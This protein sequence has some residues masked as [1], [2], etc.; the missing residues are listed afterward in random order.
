[1]ELGTDTVPEEYIEELVTPVEGRGDPA[2]TMLWSPRK[3]AGHKRPLEREEL[4]ES[5]EEGDSESG[6]AAAEI[7]TDRTKEGPGVTNETDHVRSELMQIDEGEDAEREPAPQAQTD[8]TTPVE[9]PMAIETDEGKAVQVNDEGLVS[10][11]RETE[12][13]RDLREDSARGT[14]SIPSGGPTRAGYEA[15]WATKERE[16]RS[17]CAREGEVVDDVWEV[18][19]LRLAVK[20][21]QV[22]QPGQVASG[23]REGHRTNLG[24][25]TN[26]IQG[27]D[28]TVSEPCNGNRH[29][30][31][32]GHRGKELSEEPNELCMAR[33]R[34]ETM[35]KSTFTETN[36]WEK[37]TWEVDSSARRNNSKTPRNGKW[38]DPYPSNDLSILGALTRRQITHNPTKH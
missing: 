19:Q 10:S 27:M 11:R 35:D 2:S 22:G 20:Q 26:G 12:E 28:A 15:T 3:H 25:P 9:T 32:G 6:A 34:E 16:R 24:T 1:M 31:S 21:G 30:K 36:I 7:E 33:W 5:K 18:A 13:Q 38:M 29:G 4:E 14:N 17:S 23:N 37:Q 8:D